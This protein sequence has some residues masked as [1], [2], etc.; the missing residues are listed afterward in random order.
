MN[1]LKNKEGVESD[2][3]YDNKRIISEI[4]KENKQAPLFIYLSFI[5]KLSERMRK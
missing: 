4:L 3:I 2:R 1:Y 5:A